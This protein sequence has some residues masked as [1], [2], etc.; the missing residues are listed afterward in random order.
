[1]S[2]EILINSEPQ[3][4]RVAIV[5]DGQLLEFHIERPQD[6]T[7]VG[8]IYKGRIEAVMPSIGAA[9]VDIGLPKN[10]FL[11]LS[12]IESAYESIEAPAQTPIKEVKKGQEVLVQ[13]V[14][15]SFGTKGPRLSTQIGL[16]GRYLV[17]MPLEKQ[18]GISRRIEN[19]AE[20]RRL[21]DVFKKLKLPDPVGFIVRTAASGRSEQELVRDA[22]FLYKLWK[23]LEKIA[24]E[25]KAPSLVYEEYD[26]PL[27]AIRDSFTED[28][29]KLIVD[30]KPEFY[31]IQ[32]FMRTFLSYLSR[33]V[34]LY[35]GDDL[36]AAKDVEK[37]INHI[38]ESHVY[39]K[40]KAYLIIEPTEGLVVIDVNSGGFKKK[41][42]QEDM[43]FKVNAEAAVEIARQLVLRDLG[44]IIV[45]DFIDMEREGHRRELLNILKNALSGDRAKYDILG[46]SKF[47]IVEMTRER[48]HKTVQMLSFHPCPYCKGKG[49]LRSPQTLGI[50]ALK[51]LK[52]YLKGKT[53]KQASL[54]LAPPVIDEILKDKE[55]LR[56]IEHKY[57]IKINLI[58]NPTAHLEDIT[59][60]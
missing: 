54:T 23:R 40:S 22:Q 34:E 28:V 15:E 46:I 3:E 18:G 30:S 27:R 33:K 58:S 49:K 50:F 24:Q 17:I 56:A 1:M 36:F 7:I 45:I 12:E 32:H 42:N 8:N 48:I 2:K 59:F 5:Q 43:A 21:R 9:F 55:A 29:S 14:K 13:V 51:E 35:R 31:R 41:V 25:K 16:A 26:L 44:G 4:K 39:M 47:G 38:F 19:E 11:Y 10:G 57:R 52:R 20:R 60:S 6:R 37:Q 53:L